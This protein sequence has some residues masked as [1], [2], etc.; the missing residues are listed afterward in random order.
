VRR[1]YDSL[2]PVSQPQPIDARQHVWWHRLR[3][4]GP[5]GFT[6][7]LGGLAAPL[8]TVV[9]FG[10]VIIAYRYPF[11]TFVRNG[12]LI[13]LVTA[14]VYL[15]A[16]AW[17]WSHMEKRY[18]DTLTIR[19]PR[20]GYSLRGGVSERCPECGQALTRGDES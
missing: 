6:L 4:L 18:R 16:C 7:L 13:W 1:A 15:G 17:T 12:T 11:S 10:G 5:W 19:C 3:R 8:I 2:I 9:L 14:P 20:C